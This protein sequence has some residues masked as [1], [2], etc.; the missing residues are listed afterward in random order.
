MAS[1][2]YL[3]LL[4]ISLS[5]SSPFRAYGTMPNPIKSAQN[6]Y[7]NQPGRIENY[8]TGHSSVS[9][10]EKKEASAPGAGKQ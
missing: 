9:E 4:V 3:S 5:L 6:A 1:I 2:V 8:T 10:K 7:K